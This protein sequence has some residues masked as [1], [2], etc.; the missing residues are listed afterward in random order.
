MNTAS[1][2][3]P[4]SPPSAAK[5]H[6][7]IAARLRKA[8]G[9]AVVGALAM[10]CYS[11]RQGVTVS[12][13]P[14]PATSPKCADGE[15]LVATGNYLE[16]K[17]GLAPL[18]L[19]GSIPVYPDWRYNIR[20]TG[21]QSVKGNCAAD[22]DGRPPSLPRTLGGLPY[23]QGLELQ[24]LG[25]YWRRTPTW[26]P[27][28]ESPFAVGRSSEDPGGETDELPA[29]SGPRRLS[30]RLNWPPS[31][32]VPGTSTHDIRLTRY[33]PEKRCKRTPPPGLQAG[34]LWTHGRYIYDSD[35]F[36]WQAR[37]AN[38]HDSRS[39]NRCAYEPIPENEPH[40]GI[41]EAL[42]RAD[43][44]IGQWKVNFIRLLLE[45]YPTATHTPPKISGVCPNLVLAEEP[46][47]S[48]REQWQDV[49]E[50]PAYV[51]EIKQ[52]VDHVT[53]PG[54]YVLLSLWE[55]PSIDKMTGLPT[56]RTIE[57]WRKLTNSFLT[58][59]RVLFGIV[60]E[61]TCNLN[62]ASDAQVRNAMQD[63]VDAI[64]AEEDAAGTPHHLITVPGAGAWAR[65]ISAYLPEPMR[66]VGDNIVYEAHI[67]NR[68]HQFEELWKTPA[69]SLPVIIGE[70]GPYNDPTIATMY[71]HDVKALMIEAEE[72]EVPYLAFS[73]HQKCPPNL[74]KDTSGDDPSGSVCRLPSLELTVFGK[75]LQQ[76]LAQRYGFAT[77][78]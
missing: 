76:Q 39:C 47:S 62:G 49:L 57:V 61:P 44:L 16:L 10:T 25:E 74:L 73:F 7:R 67:Y 66:I 71:E 27:N 75:W 19:S 17:A 28:P 55:D 21:C 45:S 23:P 13:P 20:I 54:G 58:N 24:V 41:K 64:R 29:R 69:R 48:T 40:P 63:V 14:E 33:Y 78:P 50:S 43:F 53:I 37:G 22:A 72:M 12:I 56:P 42:S 1:S 30:F 68:K 3:K 70:F 2:A 31:L 51:D 26:G 59:Q 34:S 8:P 36:H 38:L 60:N 5:R 6:S 18:S 15:T 52:I 11:G 32:E 35:G 65:R 9:I 77:S 46:P 4:Q